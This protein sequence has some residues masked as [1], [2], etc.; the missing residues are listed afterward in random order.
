MGWKIFIC[1]ILSKLIPKQRGR[2]W[3]HIW[4][5]KKNINFSWNSKMWKNYFAEFSVTLFLNFILKFLHPFQKAIAY[6]YKN[7]FKIRYFYFSFFSFFKR[8][9]KMY[10][11]SMLRRIFLYNIIFKLNWQKNCN[12][13]LTTI[14]FIQYFLY[15]MQPETCFSPW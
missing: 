9:R 11:G 8:E 6:S 4:D 3:S 13:K 7:K 15:L 1:Q 10:F 2:N 14:N 5:I 12:L